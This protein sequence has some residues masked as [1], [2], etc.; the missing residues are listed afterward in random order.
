MSEFISS[1]QCLNCKHCFKKNPL[2]QLLSE[3]EL[4]LLNSNRTEIDFRGGEIV[5]KQGMPLTHLA[6]LNRGLGK[7]FIETAAHRHVI[8]RYAKPYEINSG[9]GMYSDMR[10]HCSLM[11]VEDSGVCLIDIQTVKTLLRQNPV[12]QEEFIKEFS[13][14]YVSTVNHFVILTQKNMEGRIAEAI[15]YLYRHVFDRGAIRHVSKQDLADLTAMTK[16]SALR[17]MKEF[18]L[19]GVVEEDN[20]EIHLLDEKALTRIAEKA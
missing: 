1:Y 12:F 11:A 17:V 4:D 7:L 16:E 19:E 3:A 18:K 20:N 13:S 5:F 6:I 2:F 15:L 9:P 8:V 10:H 14:R